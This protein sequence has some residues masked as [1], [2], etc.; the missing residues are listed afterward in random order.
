MATFTGCMPSAIR[1][2]NSLHT[3]FTT[4]SPIMMINPLDSAALMNSFGM[5]T[6]PSILG[7]RIKAS[8]ADKLPV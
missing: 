8:M 6:V 1:S 3:R 2:S 7:Q 5:R 4:H